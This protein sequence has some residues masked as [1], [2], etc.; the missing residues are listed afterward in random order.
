MIR[1]VRAKKLADLY[2]RME[3]AE[4]LVK[5]QQRHLARLG[6]AKDDVARDAAE[7]M[8]D[9]RMIRARVANMPGNRVSLVLELSAEVLYEGYRRHDL[10]REVVGRMFETELIRGG[11]L[12]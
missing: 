2:H 10:M 6:H 9:M 4:T 1:V 3:E 11:H 12:R 5:E 8:R 7:L